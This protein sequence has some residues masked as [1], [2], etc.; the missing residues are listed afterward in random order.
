[1][2][3][4]ETKSKREFDLL[5]RA[6]PGAPNWCSR[7]RVNC[8]WFDSPQPTNTDYTRKVGF[9]Q[10]DVSDKQLCEDRRGV[11]NSEAA[12][13]EVCMS[14]TEHFDG[15]DLISIRVGRPV[16]HHDASPLTI[17]TIPETPRT[18]GAIISSVGSS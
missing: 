16:I 10:Q 14:Q 13:A 5:R 7:C 4:L 17:S 12:L 8:N 11:A 1:M 3:I 6:R 2:Q 15:D 9:L 18:G